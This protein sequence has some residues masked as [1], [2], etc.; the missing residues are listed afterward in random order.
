MV[1]RAH[2]HV[3]TAMAPTV[4]CWRRHPPP[5]ATILDQGP[6]SS[7]KD[8][9]RP[10]NIGAAI[11]RI[12]LKFS[13]GHRCGRPQDNLEAV[14]AALAAGADPDGATRRGLRSHSPPLTVCPISGCPCKPHRG[15]ERDFAARGLGVIDWGG[16]GQWPVLHLAI[17]AAQVPVRLLIPHAAHRIKEGY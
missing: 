6:P 3:G 7:I 12:S 16:N 5:T 8:H 15:G 14:A 9:A 17:Y 2:C 10:E 13:G 4:S 11:L 1:P